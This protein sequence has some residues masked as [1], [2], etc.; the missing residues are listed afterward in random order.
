MTDLSRAACRGLHNAP[1]FE[2]TDP[3]SHA[4]AKAICLN[5][6]PVLEACKALLEVELAAAAGTRGTGGGPCGTWA[7]QLITIEKKP[8]KGKAA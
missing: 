5:E 1:L 8:R 2:A 3:H 6:C 4:E 7:G